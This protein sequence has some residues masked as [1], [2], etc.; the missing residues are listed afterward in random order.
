MPEGSKFACPSCGKEF[1]WKSEIAGKR[2][3]CK[4]GA[5][6]QVPA[7]DPAKTAAAAPAMAGEHSF[8]DVYALAAAEA[9]QAAAEN[10]R[11][12]PPAA[13]TLAYAAPADAPV[14]TPPPVFTAA[15]VPLPR[16]AKMDNT[17]SSL[18]RWHSALRGIGYAFVGLLV[19]A[20]A[21]FEF[22]TISNLEHRGGGHHRMR[23]WVWI[24]YQIGGKWAVVIVL[25]GLGAL[26]V[27][28]GILAIFGK[29]HIQSEE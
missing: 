14:R 4:C 13:P 29:V 5:T 21:A 10:E 15:G 1:R 17:P 20:Y 27:L 22:I 7:T 26:M 8:D 9:E 23:I 6:V 16:R 11:A 24:L 19:C 28:A 3:K 2:A 12:A 25:G 18:E